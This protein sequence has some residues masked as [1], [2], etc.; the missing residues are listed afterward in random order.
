[1]PL[2]TYAG[3]SRVALLR[4]DHP[5]LVPALALGLGIPRRANPSQDHRPECQ[6]GPVRHDQSSDRTSRGP[7]SAPPTTGGLPSLS[8][9]VAA[10]LSGPADLVVAG[11]GSLS[12]GDPQPTI[13]RPL[14]H[15][16]QAVPGTEWRGPSLEGVEAF[17]R[18]QPP[19]PNGGQRSGLRGTLALGPESDRS[20]A[21]SGHPVGQLLAQGFLVKTSGY[22]LSFTAPPPCR[23]TPAAPC[24]AGQKRKLSHPLH[25]AALR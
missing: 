4:R 5:P 7:A 25:Q 16:L 15:G 23:P 10:A 11:Q 24:G 17:D 20:P 6:T 18:R 13:G 1:M 8:A 3:A 12:P 14:G 2:E 21:Q 22:L 19:I 9:G